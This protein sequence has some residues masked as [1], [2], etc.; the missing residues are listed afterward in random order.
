VESGQ[1]QRL[2]KKLKS[3][4]AAVRDGPRRRLGIWNSQRP[5][6][7]TW[8]RKPNPQRDCLGLTV[9]VLGKYLVR[10]VGR[11]PR[12]GQDEPTK[13]KRENHQRQD[14]LVRQAQAL[15]PSIQAV[16]RVLTLPL[17]AGFAA[18]PDGSFTA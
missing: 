6:G 12:Q 14:D 18:S 8:A 2:E 1:L 13:A 15:P 3:Y 11:T 9:L 17:A 16:V 7:S 10:L 4:P 5:P